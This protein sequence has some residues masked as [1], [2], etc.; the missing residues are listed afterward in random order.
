MRTEHQS[1]IF[2]LSKPGRVGY[3]IPE[4]DVPEI[5][6]ESIIPSD[7]LRTE[8]ADLPEVSE[9][10]IVRHYTA[11]S[12]RNHGV[13]SGFYPLGSCTMKYNPK[14]NED[15]A[16]FPGFAHIHPLQ[17][18]ETVQ[19]A[20]EMMYRLQTSLAEITGMDEVTLQPAAGAH[21]EWTGLM[22]IRAYHE[23]NGDFNRTKV[24]VPDSAHGTNPASATVAGFESITVKSD[25]RGLVDL[26][27]LKR[28]VDQDVAA[29]MLTNPNTLGLFEEHIL[30][31]AKIVH[32]AGGKLY[33]DGANANA[34]LGFAR[35]GDMGFDVVHLNLHKTFTGPHGGGGPGSGPV[36]VK[37]D[38]IPFLP[39]PVLVKEDDLYKFEYDRP[40]SIGRVKPFYGNFGINVR[41]FTYI[42]TMGPDG[43]RQVSENAVL[44][45]NYMMRRLE[46]HFD[47][48]FTQHCKHEF[49]LSGR[50]Q[51]KLGV[52]TLDIA[53]R[54][55]D[56]GY[57]PPTI[58]FPLSVE[59]AIMIEPTET[60]SKETLDEFIEKMIQIS[61]EAEETPELVQE[62]PHTT[63]VRRLDEATAARKPIL[64]Y[65]KQ[66]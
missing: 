10:Q 9:L 23:A 62:A 58:Y 38:L 45:A 22:M 66:V 42:M 37:E 31:M 39:K 2:E 51:K 55:L 25:E 1:L 3:S 41:A 34:I 6:V 33:Y 36:G 18:E 48:P 47:L 60:E 21:G 63:V 50:R 5:N 35:P 11:L 29:L 19:G 26:E 8:E 12:N 43:L 52:R 40:Q 44:N 13:D 46:P 65:I 27:D 20:M 32:E 7:Y 28:V 59:E 15:V 61:K 14:I 17:D 24:I 54:L 57:H 4:L 16:R 64:K 30:E 53:K 56:F 49:V